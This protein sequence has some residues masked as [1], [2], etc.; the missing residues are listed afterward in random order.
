MKRFVETADLPRILV[1]AVGSLPHSEPREAVDL[2]VNNLSQAPH[3]PQLPRSDPREQMWIQFSENLP[4]FQVD[5]ENLS[6][7][8]DTSGDPIAEVEEFYSNYLGV[9]AGGPVDSFQVGPDYGKGIDA[10][11]EKLRQ[12]GTTR[13]FI[14]VQV[15]GPLSFALGVTDETKKPIFYHPLFKDV[16][17]KGMGL[18]AIW[19]LEQFRPFAERVIVFFDEPSLSAY[20]SSAMLG[21]SREDVVESL[22]DVM[23]MVLE[24]GGIPGIHCCGNT[25]WGL[26]MAT[27]ARIIN[28]DAVDYADTMT[29]YAGELAQ[30]LDRGGVLAWGA[31]RNTKEVRGETAD[32]VLFRIRQGVTALEK[33][34]LD[35]ALLTEKIIITPACG[36]AGLTMEDTAHAYGLMAQLESRTYRDH[37]GI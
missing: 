12:N 15:T 23:T 9:T 20:G 30:F 13:P 10:F 14:K 16:A 5:L 7:Y 19:L 6:Y 25:D 27:C 31:V 32:D 11:L 1:T 28:F 26:L 8:F 22:D 21:V 2:I 18:K 24:R 3:L 29:L 37:E 33:R 36:C 35:R 17:V 4:R 34:G